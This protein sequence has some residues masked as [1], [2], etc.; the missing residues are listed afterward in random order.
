MTSGK[1][2]GWRLALEVNHGKII[3]CI[4]VVRI[5]LDC[6]AQFRLRTV[7]PFLSPENDSKIIVRVRIARVIKHRLTEGGKCLLDMILL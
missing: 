7:E 3:M 6:P 5:D 1:L 4:T 2:D